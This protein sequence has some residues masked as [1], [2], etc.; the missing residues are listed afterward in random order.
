MVTSRTIRRIT[1][2]TAAAV[3][4]A[5]LLLWRATTRLTESKVDAILRSGELIGMTLPDAGRTLGH[6]VPPAD[7][8]IIRFDQFQG[9]SRWSR[10]AVELEIVNG[11]VTA[12]DWANPETDEHDQR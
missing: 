1:L 5:G 4:A 10:R 2:W 8:G 6:S 12:A 11:R 3:V 7:D 9:S